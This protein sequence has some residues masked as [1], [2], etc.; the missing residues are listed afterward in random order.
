MPNQTFYNLTEDKQ[1]SLLKACKMEFSR[2]PLHEASISNIIKTCGISRGSFYQYF[3]DKEDAYYFILKEHSK[4]RQESFISILKEE[5][6]DLFSAITKFFQMTLDELE[7][8]ERQSYFKHVFLNMNHKI[9]NTFTNGDTEDKFLH[10][11][12]SIKQYIN[13]EQL[14][15]ETEEELYHAIHLVRIV[16]L[17]NLIQHFAK[18]LSKEKAMENF[19]I[20]LHLLKKGLSK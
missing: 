14:S 18:G 7:D 17:N 9:Q 13:Q 15:T 5:D 4:Q 12:N 6:G 3:E 20:E 10:Y 8:E 16:M 11:L 2:A 19:K 1:D